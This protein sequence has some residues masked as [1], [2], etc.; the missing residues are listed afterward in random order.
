MLKWKG[1]Q[2]AESSEFDPKWQTIIQPLSCLI[3]TTVCRLPSLFYSQFFCFQTLISFLA[4]VWAQ[5]LT[6]TVTQTLCYWTLNPDLV[7]FCALST[8]NFTA[9]RE[10]FALGL[11]I[12]DK[13]VREGKMLWIDAN[14]APLDS[15][16]QIKKP[17]S[18]PQRWH[19]NLHGR[20]W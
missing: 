20:C 3:M 4:A 6:P 10:A 18:L 5:R 19:T 11:E 9:L 16:F 1:I 8:T 17:Y 14:F 12:K 13:K 2:I 7:K 15:K